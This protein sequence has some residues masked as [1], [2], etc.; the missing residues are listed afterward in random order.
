MKYPDAR[1]LS[2][3]AITASASFAPFCMY[4]STCC[5]NSSH[6][7]RLSPFAGQGFPFAIISRIIL[8]AHV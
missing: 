3:V 1:L 4:P 2:I 7:L 6:I 8:T 5:R